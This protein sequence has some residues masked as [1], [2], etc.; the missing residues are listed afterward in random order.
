MDGAEKRQF[1]K[2][3]LGIAIEPTHFDLERHRVAPTEIVATALRC[4]ANTLRVGMFSHQ[5][6]AYYPS[7][8]APHA[9][10]LG[11]RDLL[12]EFQAACK[13]AGITLAVYMNSKWD[14]Q[15]YFE[16]P[17]WA[18]RK[19]GKHWEYPV[20]SEFKIYAMCPNSPFLAYF[21]SLLREV[22]SRY[23]PDVMYIDNFGMAIDCEC[24]F[25]V[26]AF[27]EASSEDRPLVENWGD[28]VW[29]KFR[30]WSR[31]RNFVLARRLTEAIR[32]ERRETCVVFNRGQFRSRT[33]HAN[34]E[35]VSRFAHDIADNVHGESSVRLNGFSFAHI[36][37]QCAFARAIDAPMWTWVEYQLRPWSYV[38]AP[39]AETKIKAAKVLANG[40]RPM[41]W[42]LPCAPD[43]DHQG[44]D[45]VAAVYGLAS[46]FPEYFQDSRQEPFIAVL[47]SSQTAE[48]YVAGDDAKHKEYLKEFS[49][50]LSL[51]RHNHMP[52]DILL[53][54]HLVR[55]TLSRYR[56]LILP[57]A[58]ALSDEQCRAVAAFVEAGGGLLASFET[59][60]YD[61]RGRR[62]NEFGLAAVLGA[63]YVMSLPLQHE[64][65]S[66]SYSV[67][68]ETK[69]P[70]TKMFAPGFLLP[71]GGRYVGVKPTVQAA[72]LSTLLRRCRYY[73]DFPGQPTEFPGL[74]ANEYGRGRVLYVPGEFGRVYEEHGFPHYGGIVLDAVEWMTHGAPAVRTELPD[75]VEVNIA[76][77]RSGALVIHLVNCSADLSRPVTRVVP[78]SGATISIRVPDAKPQRARAL[79]AAVDL[80]AVREGDYLTIELPPLKEY[81]VVVVASDSSGK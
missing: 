15:K 34:P 20:K 70:A 73:C 52:A 36:N 28:P 13:D 43:C 3:V 19:G 79:Q 22:T 40:A 55:E 1:L 39:P 61:D 37:E 32:S 76:R 23:G 51:A 27:R 16:H 71:A 8:I 81:E 58:A 62:R 12:R 69:H 74:V 63:G 72:R 46:R 54:R 30:H 14:T 29:Q 47:Y 9:P 60:L 26:E 17:D 65:Y 11:N 56:V 31:E 48:E 42:R 45:G 38:S 44:L 68:T 4:H 59:S 33:G 6:H 7:A 57:N 24:A 67:V 49:G 41:T 10:G 78:I 50:V 21:E 2:S 80:H 18:I 53:D 64:G 75:T 5:G 66:T 35:D 25:C 77:S